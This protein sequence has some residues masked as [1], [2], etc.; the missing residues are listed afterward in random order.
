MRYGVGTGWAAGTI[1]AFAGVGIAFQVALAQ[2][3]EKG[4]AAPPPAA[5]QPKAQAA[6]ADAP[7]DKVLRGDAKCTMCHDAPEILSIGKTRHGA[8]ADPR[9]PTCTSCHGESE[10][11]RNNPGATKPDRNFAHNTPANDRAGACLAC[12]GADRHLAFW[13]NGRHKKNEVA[14]NDCHQ[15]HE[16]KNL[17]LRAQ[18]PKI[19][20]YERTNRQLEYET[21]TGC[22]KSVRAQIA[23]T[24]H[25]PLMEGKI[26]CSSCHNPHGALSPAMVNEES[27]NQLCTTCHTDKRGPFINEH[28]PVEENCLTCH[29]PH[30]SIHMKLLAERA[31]NVCQ[32]CHDAAR[33]PGSYYSGNQGW[34]GAQNTRLI[35]RACLN[36]HTAIHGSNAPAARGQFFLR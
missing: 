28:P 15:L 20:P 12:H 21:C 7:K 5:A 32:D 3:P 14:C 24:S 13:D 2:E 1:A 35:A 9:T 22:H 27:V 26:N 11:H 8:V 19:S 36:C 31:P 17:L 29:T 23:K 30:G 34:T 10:A 25:H 6:A 33:H 4:Q 16:A 18:N